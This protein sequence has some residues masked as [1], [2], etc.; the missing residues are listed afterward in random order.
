L[1]H[2]ILLSSRKEFKRLNISTPVVRVGR[3][4]HK[5]DPPIMRFRA[6]T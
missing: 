1:S 4:L 6:D 2:G 3:D 5:G